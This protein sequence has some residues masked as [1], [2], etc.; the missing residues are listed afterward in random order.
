MIQIDYTHTQIFQLG[1]NSALYVD[2]NGM[3]LFDSDRLQMNK[4]VINLSLATQQAHGCMKHGHCQPWCLSH[5]F[6]RVNSNSHAPN[7]WDW[8]VCR[9]CLSPKR[10]FSLRHWLTSFQRFS[11][12]SFESGQIWF[13]AAGFAI[14]SGSLCS[15]SSWKIWKDVATRKAVMWASCFSIC[16]I[17]TLKKTSCA[18]CFGSPVKLVSWLL[19]HTK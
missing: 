6:S 4:N 2:S 12:S 3:I 13:A 14:S 15:G 7:G 16:L 9:F 10:F 18:T 5:A 11:V 1:W 17:D 19:F 8:V